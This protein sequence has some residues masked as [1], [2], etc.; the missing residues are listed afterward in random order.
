MEGL[1]LGPAPF[2][3]CATGSVCSKSASAPRAASPARLVVILVGSCVFVSGGSTSLQQPPRA[4]GGRMWLCEGSRLSG[5]GPN[6]R[7]E[8]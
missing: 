2:D 6:V 5:L 7:H 1:G 4:S 8:R 3:K